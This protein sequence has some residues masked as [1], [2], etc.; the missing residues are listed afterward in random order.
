MNSRRNII[1]YSSY[2]ESVK[3][4]VQEIFEMIEKLR[5]QEGKRGF[6]TTDKNS[7]IRHIEIVVLDLLGAWETDP[8][9]FIGYSRGKSNFTKQ[10]GAYWNYEISSSYITHR[11]FLEVIDTLG[12]LMFIENRTECPGFKEFS[13]RMRAG[14]RLKKEFKQRG[15]NW[16]DIIYA[17]NAPTIIV[18]D[19]NKNIIPHPDPKDFDLSQAQKN[20]D[21]INRNLDWSLLNLHVSDET[22]DHLNSKRRKRLDEREIDQLDSD[23]DADQIEPIEFQNRRLRRVFSLGSFKNGGRFYGGWWQHVPSEFRKHIEIE[24][25]ITVEMDYSTMQ[26][27]ILYA[28]AGLEPPSDSYLMSHWN[29]ELRKTAKKAFLQ[30]MN[31]SKSSANENQWHRFAPHIEDMEKPNDWSNLNEY[32][33]SKIKREKFIE[34]TGRDYNEFLSDLLSLHEPISDRFFSKAWGEMQFLDSQIAESVMLKLLDNEPPIT[35]LPIHDSFI[36]R[37][38]AE[39]LLDDAM[40]VAFYDVVGVLPKVDKDETIYDSIGVETDTKSLVWSDKEFH[41]STKEEVEKYR[42]YNLREEQWR[43]KFGPVG[44]E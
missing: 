19:E 8:T 3:S 23:E 2:S 28:Q 40:K 38:G 10:G 24:G 5:K 29:P 14:P 31:S 33:Q 34:I 30:L 7:I 18:K 27:R 37:R 16:P 11:K 21:R 36:V 32:E 17:S 39:K 44:Y 25:A 20:L 42:K 12:Q 9:M 43:Y 15:L 4:L 6:S 22:Y 13:S 1:H 41:E 35:A 26:P